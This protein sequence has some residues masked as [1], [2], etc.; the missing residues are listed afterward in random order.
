M[1]TATLTFQSPTTPNQWSNATANVIESISLVN[2]SNW[3]GDSSNTSGTT[4][5]NQGY[6]VLNTSST[7]ET[8]SDLSIRLRYGWASAFSNRT[9]DSLNAR[10]VNGAQILAGSSS[11]GGYQTI[12]SS[13]TDISPVTS[14]FINFNY[15]NTTAT[16]A[17]WD[18]AVIEFQIVSTRSGGGSSIE[19]RVYAGELFA[20]YIS[21]DDATKFNIWDGSVWKAGFLKR[22]NGSTWEYAM[23]QRWT[24][25]D[26]VME[27]GR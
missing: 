1:A 8:M 24:G 9:W 10:I 14:N 21:S 6:T 2:D 26:W 16:K 15:V 27:D 20:T 17:N 18:A 11:G 7:F 23:A 5:L 25:T 3:A 13:I 19:R 22:Y 12:A 4:T